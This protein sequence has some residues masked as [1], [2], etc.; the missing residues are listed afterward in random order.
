MGIGFLNIMYLFY[1]TPILSLA[2]HHIIIHSLSSFATKS[3]F[4]MIE[5]GADIFTYSVSSIGNILKDCLVDGNEPWR[6]KEKKQSI[7]I[8]YPRY[9]NQP[10][11]H[12]PNKFIS[13]EEM[14]DVVG[15]I[16]DIK[17]TKFN[18]DKITELPPYLTE[19]QNYFKTK[20]KLKKSKSCDNIHAITKSSKINR[21]HSFVLPYKLNN[22]EI[23]I[24]DG[25][26]TDTTAT[27]S[28]SSSFYEWIEII[29]DK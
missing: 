17:Y 21:R 22:M 20:K 14:I 5:K 2:S 28:T 12:H 1:L 10:D 26:E 15:P 9:I 7:Y 18:I 8:K 16:D 6:Y 11:Q 24:L 13:F 19:L 23:N 29:E 3:A 4:Y 25:L 27:S